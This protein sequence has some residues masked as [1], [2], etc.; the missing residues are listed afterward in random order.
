MK[1]T[2][3]NSLTDL[4]K[5]NKKKSF[6]NFFYSVYTFLFKRMSLAR[7]ILLW[8]VLIS[9][10][11]ALLLWAPFSQNSGMERISFIDAL[12]VSSSSF[13]DTGLTTIS[14]SEQFNFFGQFI[15]FMLIQ[16]GGIGWF[17]IK[18]FVFYFFISK[19]TK[20]K[21][22]FKRKLKEELEE[23]MGQIDKSHALGLVR[24][25]VFTSVLITIFGGVIFGISFA[26]IEPE[27][28]T[29]STNPNLVG[30][31]GAAMWT[32]F[33]H[34]GASVNNAGFDI[35]EGNISMQGY[36]GNYWIQILTIIFFIIGGIGFSVIYDFLQWIKYRSSG[37]KFE[38]SLLTKISFVTYFLVATIGL[39]LVFLT[40]GINAM[41]NP[42]EAYLTSGEGTE[43]QRWFSLFFNTFSTRNAGFST[44]P[45]GGFEDTL[46]NQCIVGFS[47]GTIYIYIV[48]M[49]IGSGPGSTAGG[50]RTTVLAIF[51][52]SI[53]SYMRGNEETNIFKKKISRTQ[54]Y[55]V[56]I[57][58]SFSIFLIFLTTLI[59]AMAESALLSSPNSS[60]DFLD[61]LFISTS[62]FGTTGLSTFD[63]S[64]FN[65]WAK[66]LLIM[67]MFVGQLGIGT[68]LK[69]FRSEK[70]TVQ[71]KKYIV[72]EVSLG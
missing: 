23:E 8:Y 11:G 66:L 5:N 71:Q 64:N 56:F 14:I 19:I 13:S 2:E 18:I 58:F 39:G 33:F 51:I 40:E 31:W 52:L 32:G 55:T 47:D 67:Q 53:I 44:V 70:S 68:T 42:T 9:L 15:I 1:A 45:I 30:D 26:L 34:A 6:S 12:F 61:L 4:S 25:A 57:T 65:T 41:N 3:D 16:I 37:K 60:I 50:I 43:G 63:L 49:F 72:E 62:A 29:N 69:Q 17:A 20:N 22:I 38:F 7:Q 28:F 36:Y 27:S 35:F 46:N 10:L 48:M 54:V 59:L 24:T 21:H